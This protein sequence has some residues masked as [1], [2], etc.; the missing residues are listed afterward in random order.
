V[1][2]KTKIKLDYANALDFGSPFPYIWRISVATPVYLS[3]KCTLIGDVN[4]VF[5]D[6][7]THLFKLDILQPVHPGKTQ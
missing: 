5:A 3:L 7:D 4:N 6:K 1:K 2:V